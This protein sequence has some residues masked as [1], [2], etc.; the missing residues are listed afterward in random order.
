MVRN[1]NRNRNGLLMLCPD[2]GAVYKE[3]FALTT[4]KRSVTSI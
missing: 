2:V 3:D 4:E 1:R